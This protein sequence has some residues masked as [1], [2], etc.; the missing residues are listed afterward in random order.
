MKWFL[1]ILAF[2]AVVLVK[3]CG[4]ME[5]VSDS[6]STDQQWVSP[7]WR[8]V[9]DDVMGGYSVSTWSIENNEV[10]VFEG[11]VS[12]RNNGGF[13]SVRS[14]L[15][16]ELFKDADGVKIQLVG[17]QNLYRL[18]LRSAKAPMGISY[19]A[20][21]A[22]SGTMQDVFIPFSAFQAKWR[23]RP[24]PEAPKLKPKDVIGVGLLISNQQAGPF[25][26]EVHN[27]EGA[28]RKMT[29]AAPVP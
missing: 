12:L 14:P 3:G 1:V 13:A 6:G 9:N 20:D 27:I 26:V 28:S 21:I 29:E 18:C 16:N 4:T 19:Q 2:G 11:V 17:D 7:N 22:T 5:V 10:G 23:G 15:K 8:I 24:V 25:R